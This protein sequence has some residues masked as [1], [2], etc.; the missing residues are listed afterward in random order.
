MYGHC[1][2]DNDSISGEFTEVVKGHSAFWCRSLCFGVGVYLG[3]MH[4]PKPII[5]MLMMTITYVKI[6]IHIWHITF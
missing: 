5:C 4:H 6:Y 3:F 2:T 1:I